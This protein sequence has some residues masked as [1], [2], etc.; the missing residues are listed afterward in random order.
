[1]VKIDPSKIKPKKPKISV[2]LSLDKENIKY[3]KEDIEKYA[4]G[5]TLSAVFDDILEKVVSNLKQIR[6]KNGKEEDGDKSKED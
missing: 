1:M 6:E 4:E 2:S 5:V 3:L